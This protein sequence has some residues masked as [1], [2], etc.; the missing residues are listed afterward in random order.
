MN[1]LHSN[2]LLAFQ[3]EEPTNSSCPLQIQLRLGCLKTLGKIYCELIPSHEDALRVFLEAATL[4]SDNFT[5]W[6]KIGIVAVRL[7]E[8]DLAKHAF[9]QVFKRNP[10]HWN[11]IEYLITLSYVLADYVDCLYYCA[12]GLGKDPNFIKGLVF[13]DFVFEILPC[14]KESLPKHIPNSDKLTGGLPYEI[15]WKEKYLKEVR[16]FFQ[17]QKEKSQQLK[18]RSQSFSSQEL[19]N[20]NVDN[21]KSWT[22]LCRV[23]KDLHPKLHSEEVCD[24]FFSGI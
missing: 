13:R 4:D 11:S 22:E 15:S 5:L 19:L 16:K 3:S 1:S 21:I 9:S 12:H 2:N 20:V 14:L 23:V 24:R 10:S 7:V 8:Y 18:C 6:N 17:L